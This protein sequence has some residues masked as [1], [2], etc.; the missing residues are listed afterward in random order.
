MNQ[1]RFGRKT[2]EVNKWKK[3]KKKKN[4]IEKK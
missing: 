2:E 1:K 4:I 3:K